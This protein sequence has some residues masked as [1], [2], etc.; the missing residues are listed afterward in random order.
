VHQLFNLYFEREGNIGD[1]A[2]LADAAAAAGMDRDAVAAFLASGELA[3]EVD[4]EVVA[5]A[6]KHRISGVP[7][8]VVDSKY[9]VEGAQ[10]PEVFGELFDELAAR[11]AR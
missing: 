7:F 4:A 6:R 10:E 5:W 9:T 11:A 8:F 3:A 2:A 1:R